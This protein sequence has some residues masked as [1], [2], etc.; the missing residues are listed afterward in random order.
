MAGL[1]VEIDA[2]RAQW[3]LK[4][5]SQ[6]RWVSALR[7]GAHQDDVQAVA[8]RITLLSRWAE[9]INK[10]RM[11]RDAKSFTRLSQ[12]MKLQVK[13]GWQ[14][15]EKSEG[16]ELE[17]ADHG[18]ESD[19]EGEHEDYLHRIQREQSELLSGLGLEAH[20][21]GE[22]RSA[23]AEST[24]AP[25][26]LKMLPPP[27][28][29]GAIERERSTRTESDAQQAGIHALIGSEQLQ[30]KPIWS[31]GIGTERS[32]S[33]MSGDGGRS[34][35]REP[36]SA[37]LSVKGNRQYPESPASANRVAGHWVR[38]SEETILQ[39]TLAGLPWQRQD[40][41]GERSQDDDGGT[42]ADDGTRCLMADGG[43]HHGRRVLENPVY[44]H[45]RDIAGHNTF[46]SHRPA[47]TFADHVIH[48]RL[49]VLS[50]GV[51][52]VCRLICLELF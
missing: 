41:G 23:I 52:Q 25:Q 44:N 9:L 16:D 10:A 39:K 12:R 13:G 51:E 29:K 45:R 8:R 2:A 30:S 5:S 46:S 19:Q 7:E 49:T 35:P 34:T 33:Q 47:D 24:R 22:R 21:A 36:G 27:A 31:R 1:Q 32:P 18:V 50:A 26:A 20:V 38:G 17:D 11:R 3:H 6:E 43:Q 40:N 48:D 28:K 37:G 14:S 42:R 4:K 15:A